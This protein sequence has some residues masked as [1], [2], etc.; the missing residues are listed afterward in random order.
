MP[1]CNFD[2]AYVKLSNYLYENNINIVQN[3]FPQVL[4]RKSNNNK[5]RRVAEYHRSGSVVLWGA[6]QIYRWKC[7]WILYDCVNYLS[8]VDCVN[9]RGITSNEV[10]IFHIIKKKKKENSS[11]DSCL[12]SLDFSH[13]ICNMLIQLQYIY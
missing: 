4:Y 1:V 9:L 12:I 11:D 10:R 6:H 5:R 3:I 13:G 8:A 2:P 7:L